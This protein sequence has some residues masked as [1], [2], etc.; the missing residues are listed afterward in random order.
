MKLIKLGSKFIITSN[1]IIHRLD[2]DY[3]PNS[4]LANLKKQ[5]PIIS[6][7]EANEYLLNDP[8][9]RKCEHCLSKDDIEVK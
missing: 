4:C 9:T 1:K 7:K 3:K 5:Y 6:L 2:G 8:F